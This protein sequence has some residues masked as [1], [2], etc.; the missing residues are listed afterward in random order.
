[1]QLY[2]PRDGT[3]VFRA[4]NFGDDQSSTMRITTQSHIFLRGRVVKLFMIL[5]S[6]VL[7]G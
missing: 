2:R 3:L 6:G 4:T 5:Y 1:M 7:V